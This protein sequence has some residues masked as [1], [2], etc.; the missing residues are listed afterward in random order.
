MANIEQKTTDIRQAIYGEAVRETLASGIEAINEEVVGTTGRQEALETTFNA[1]VINAG[2]SNAEIVVARK[3]EIDLVTKIDKIDTAIG[4]KANQS[5][6]DV[7]NDTTI[8]SILSDLEDKA[9]Q[10]EVRLKEIKLNLEDMS[11]DTLGAIAGT[12]T[13]NL[14]SIPQ[15]DS[16]TN[17]KI[18]ANYKQ[19]LDSKYLNSKLEKIIGNDMTGLTSALA[20][21]TTFFIEIPLTEDAPI[22]EVSILS[23]KIGYVDLFIATKDTSTATIK[24]KFRVN[25]EI[26]LNHFTLNT[27]ALA[28]DYF[29]INDANSAV[30]WDV[31]GLGYKLFSLPNNPNVNDVITFAQGTYLTNIALNVSVYIKPNNIQQGEGKISE[32][33]VS[34]V[35]GSLVQELDATGGT[36]TTLVNKKDTNNNGTLMNFNF[37]ANDGWTGTSL[38]FDGVNDGVISNVSLTGDFTILVSLSATLVVGNNPRIISLNNDALS[39]FIF[40]TGYKLSVSNTA[41]PTNTSYS[42]VEGVKTQI[43]LKRKNTILSLYV[44]GISLNLSNNV[45]TPI[46]TTIDFGNKRGTYDRG[47]KG[48]LYNVLTFNEALAD[49]DIFLLLN[50]VSGIST[51]MK[52]SEDEYIFPRTIASS[53][54]TDEGKTVD[55]EIISLRQAIADVPTGGGTGKVYLERPSDGVVHFQVT[56]NGNIASLDT[57]NNSGDTTTVMTD[58]GIL[59][60]PTNYDADGESIRL[61]VVCH[62]AGATPFPSKTLDG[63]GKILGDPQRVLTKM[64]YAIYDMYANPY[65]LTG[66]TS[67]LH[68]G[69]PLVLQCY[70]KGYEYI[71]KN[72]NVKTDG[73]FASGSSMGGLSSFQIAQSGAIP[74]IAQA[75]FNPCIDIF[76]QAYCNPWTTYSYQRSKIAEYFKF[77]GIVPTWTSANPPSTEEIQYF[78]DNIDKLIGHYPI[79]KNI[80]NTNFMALFDVVPASGIAI[81]TNE[82]TLYN[83]FIAT[84]PVP[85]KVWHNIDDSVVNYRYSKYWINMIRRSGQLAFLRPFTT[86]GHSGWASGVD[87]SMTDIDGAIFT[88]KTSQYECYLWFKRFDY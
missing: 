61:C 65:E 44:N 75:G 21:T 69:N 50:K 56:V 63:T 19:L 59:V 86:G 30:K 6:L 76:K 51:L 14:L 85:V 35:I 84:H 10:N 88:A 64:G 49:E 54:Y 7:I 24:N 81:P 5:S 20:S 17:E 73:I 36:G 43:V 27:N 4:L 48:E 2:D 18:S 12:G 41:V 62:G 42:M 28:G 74:V 71:V 33:S 47:F 77:T 55:T 16:V 46:I 80:T 37:D 26:G 78:K 38:K 67:E 34:S 87:V 66:S 29:G 15:D 53:V 9:N 11:A 39:L 1:L 83:T 3:G 13:F 79:I 45:Y 60:L 70:I 23:T 31:K 8:P 57:D 22:L 82:E 40:A 32:I 25:L 52:N 58:Y 68:Y 72:Y